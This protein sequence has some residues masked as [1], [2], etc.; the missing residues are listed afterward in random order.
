MVDINELVTNNFHQNVS[1]LQKNHRAIYEKLL[2]Y[3]HYISQNKIPEKFTL[4]YENNGFDVL[5]HQTNKYLYNKQSTRFVQI[6]TESVNFKKNENLFEGFK[7]LTPSKNLQGYNFAF[8]LFKK[9]GEKTR[10]MRHIYKF[11]FFGTGLHIE[12]ITK[13]IGADY[14]L[15]VE[16]NIALFRLSLFTT[17]YFEIAKKSQLFFAVAADE[18]E[19]DL[20]GKKFLEK[21]PYYNHY[22]K[23]F[24]SVFHNEEKLKRFHT[25]VISQSHLNFFYNSI[26]EQYT[27][28]I[29][30][31]THNYNFLNL[32]AEQLKHY[33]KD[34]SV[35]LVAP[36]PSLDQ[37]I[38]FLKKNSNKSF[39]VAL[40]ATLSSLELAGIKP[41]IVTHFDGFDRSAI[42]FK[43]LQDTKFIAN[44]LLLFSARTPQKIVNMFDKKRIFFFETGTNYKQGFGEISAFCAG[45]ATYLILIAL[46]FENIYLVGLDL[47]LNQQTLQTHSG[48]YSYNLKADASKDTLN[49]RNSIIE[50]AGN[51]QNKVKTTP[52]FGHSINAINEITLGLKQ[53]YQT[54]Y[55]C[56]NGALFQN[57]KSAHCC[58]IK[59]TPTAKKSFTK[60][61]KQFQHNSSSHL[62][63]N[64]KIFLSDIY[65][66][67]NEKKNY[68]KKFLASQYEERNSF[69]AALKQLRNNLC[70]CHEKRCEV[71][72]LL[73]ENYTNFIYGF[74][75][76][77]LNTEGITTDIKVIQKKLAANL[78]DILYDFAKHF[79]ES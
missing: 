36:G 37:N 24:E 56:N 42:H 55:N 29:D 5:N 52:N 79:K 43:K 53:E 11:I 20:I 8:D 38:E 49:F 14:Y 69:L 70:L 54:V 31:L 78:L 51:L 67:A 32:T 48:G 15:F 72:S 35:I 26:L 75:F 25:L 2:A 13:K 34:K 1:Y 4:H 28:P 40:S 17:K 50:V 71:L 27:R 74:I 73:F 65:N 12:N 77:T 47:A 18:K 68:I 44:S 6:M 41:D 57:T 16:D 59:V 63:I 23:F 30:Y 62:A 33:C 7:L 9:Y 76:D 58:D 66:M 64:E 19:F 3:E 46:G 45:S 10:K 21:E 22:I 39:I 60:L 61:K